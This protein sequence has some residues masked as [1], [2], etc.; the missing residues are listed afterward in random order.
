MINSRKLVDLHP[1]VSSK[2]TRLLGLAAQAGIDLLI[3]STYRDHESQDA[4]YAYGRTKTGPR[5]TKAA[6]GQSYHNFRV[7]FDVVPMQFGKPVWGT[8][9]DDLLLWQ[10]IGRLGELVGLEWGGRWKT[11][12]DFPHFQFTGGRDLAWF[13]SGRHL[14]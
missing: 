8:K 2:A 14:A 5:R 1:L 6:G 7:A 12:K 9:G 11:F 3:T 13:Q 4:L 10:H